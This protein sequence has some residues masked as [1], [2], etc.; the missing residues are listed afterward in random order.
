MGAIGTVENSYMDRVPKEL[1]S[2]KSKNLRIFI[3]S[4]IGAVGAAVFGLYHF[5][6]KEEQ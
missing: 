3:A 1:K 5:F 4:L 2:Q 6:K